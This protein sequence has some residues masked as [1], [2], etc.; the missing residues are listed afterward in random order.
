MRRRRWLAMHR[1]IALVRVGLASSWVKDHM[2]I[3]VRDERRESCEGRF[4]YLISIGKYY[5]Y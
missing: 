1:L 2:E 4:A 3:S 5:A